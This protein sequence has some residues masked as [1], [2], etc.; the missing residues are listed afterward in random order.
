MKNIKI[1]KAL[2]LVCVIAMLCQFILVPDIMVS[3]E[4]TSLTFAD[5]GVNDSTAILGGQIWGQMSDYSDVSSLAGQSFEG[6]ITLGYTE[7][8]PY[9]AAHIFAKD[10]GGIG[11]FA[12]G[13]EL[14]GVGI[15][16]TD[17]T[18]NTTL[19]SVPMADY[20]ITLTEGVGFTEFKLSVIIDAISGRDAVLLI[21]LNDQK[22]FAGT[23]EGAASFLGP[24]AFVWGFNAPISI[25]S[26]CEVPAGVTYQ[27]VSFTDFNMADQ[28]FAAGVQKTGRPTDITTLDGVRI[29][30]KLQ[31]GYNGNDIQHSIRFGQSEATG[32]TCWNG[33]GF[34][35]QSENELVLADFVNYNDREI[36][37]VLNIADYN[38]TYTN[39]MF[40]EFDFT[41]QFCHI[42]D[43][44]HTWVDVA[45]NGIP[46]YS[47][48]IANLQDS[49]GCNIQ[50]WANGAPIRVTSLEKPVI[51]RNITFADF[52]MNDSEVS[53]DG[54]L[55]GELNTYAD[56]SSLAGLAFEGYITLGYTEAHPLTS[57]HVFGK[58]AGGIGVFA[59]GPEQL[60]IGIYNADG[61]KNTT[62]VSV[63]IAD[64][65]ISYTK[66]IGFS[67]FKL[68]VKIKA[69]SGDNVSLIIALNDQQIYANTVSG[70]A[71]LLGPKTFVWGFN[72]PIIIRSTYA[73]PEETPYNQVSFLDFGMA[74]Q[75]FAAG[76][77]KTGR[78]TDITTLDG[79]CIAGKLQMGYN[80]NDIQH[81]IRFGQSEAAGSTCWNG[82]GFYAKSENELV[83]ADFTNHNSREIIKILNI[84][85]YD[86]TYADG[87]FG[88][89]DFSIKFANIP[90]SRHMWVDVTVN[91]K[92]FYSGLLADGQDTLDCNIQLWANGATIGVKSVSP[93]PAQEVT[94][95][96]FGMEHGKVDT[97][98]QPAGELTGVDNLNNV[99]FTG[100]LT[101]TDIGGSFRIGTKHGKTA[102]GWNGIGIA[103]VSESRLELRSYSSHSS[104]IWLADVDIANCGITY[105][106]ATGF[107]QFLLRITFTYVGEQ[108]VAVKVLINGT[109]I[110]SG[111]IEN[112]Q[113]SLDKGIRFDG[114]SPIYYNSVSD[115]YTEVTFSDF[116]VSDITLD[117]T[118]NNQAR[119]VLPG[120]FTSMDGVAFFGKVQ[121][122]CADEE[123]WQHGLYVGTNEN[124]DTGIV[125]Y[126]VN[127]STLGIWKKTGSGFWDGGRLANININ[128]C[129]V[130][131]DAQT[132]FSEFDLQMYFQF[133]GDAD[134]QMKVVINGYT[135]YEDIVT[136]MQS[137]MGTRMFIYAT[138][139]PIAVKSVS[140]GEYFSREDSVQN[141]FASFCGAEAVSFAKHWTFE[142][143]T[144]SR[145][146]G[147][148]NM[149][150]LALK[151]RIYKNFELSVQYYQSANTNDA[152][153]VGMGAS[154]A[155]KFFTDESGNYGFAISSG[156]SLGNRLFTLDADSYLKEGWHTI[157]FVVSGKL[158]KAY[159]DN[160][161]KFIA[162]ALPV[163]YSGGYV[164]LASGSSTSQLRNFAITPLSDD[165][166]CI[167]DAN[168]NTSV[169]LADL[170]RLKKHIQGISG[171]DVS[172]ASVDFNND[173]VATSNDLAMLRRYLLDGSVKLTVSN[174]IH[175]ED[176]VMPIGGYFGPHDEYVTDAFYR[177]V[178]E[179]GINTIVRTDNNYIT[180]PDTVFRSLELADQYHVYTFVHDSSIAGTATAVQRRELLQRYMQY[181]YFAGLFIADEPGTNYYYA[182]GGLEDA[183]NRPV[184]A[185]DYAKEI[186]DISGLSGYV[187]LLP[188]YAE[189]ECG[190][191]N[192]K[193][194]VQEYCTTVP[195]AK[196]LSF[197][198]YPFDISTG[199]IFKQYDLKTYFDNMTVIRDAA[200]NMGIPFWGFIRNQS[201]GQNLTE[202]MYQ[203]NVNTN[204]AMGAKGIEYYTLFQKNASDT[205]DCLI[206][207]DGTTTQAYAYA[208]KINAQIANMDEILMQ[209]EHKGIIA[210]GSKAQQHTADVNCRLEAFKE[211]TSVTASN[212]ALVGCFEYNDKTVLCVVNYDMSYAQ[213]ITLQF[214]GAKSLTM[215]T[216]STQ[217]LEAAQ[218]HTIRLGAGSAA[219]LVVE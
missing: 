61:S 199:I 5:F 66:D 130:T 99:A 110:Y 47:G 108:N 12:N 93:A 85:D 23:A 140:V 54:Q 168:E 116:G 50:L 79:V 43:T 81:S 88:E 14:L 218:S 10:A 191:E 3:A 105:Q 214:S 60:G 104:Y 4:E 41:I 63:P 9:T 196:Y 89:F 162:V 127:T 151:D 36:I 16:N 71:S 22:I 28:T 206:K 34:Y 123:D 205:T 186:N 111:I 128:D 187:N 76:V 29:A 169:N 77:Q 70:I 201:K 167:G 62:L 131:Y 74:D 183:L 143:G 119:G 21:K 210:V 148:E 37:N 192:Y 101:F 46:F 87:M 118:G 38:I 171:A 114:T 117:H 207:R 2:A 145:K 204:L 102:Y 31:M 8:H 125:V 42:A 160:A 7:A 65:G 170:V 163:A 24:K 179:S 80:G 216:S 30:G 146:A 173:N 25:R 72:A 193:R 51:Y 11:V 165:S 91:E 17:G 178:A 158:V 135:V 211:L 164:Y 219:L 215:Y 157:R 153:I 177:L 115:R 106:H 132:G 159:V 94:F 90:E 137:L 133:V 209:S 95:A 136:Q 120:Q 122:N 189:I 82:I 203:W 15:Y 103:P 19:V 73:A 195:N 172:I 166:A 161:D 126:P 147:A 185:Y 190:F 68:G 69:V 112:L 48:L 197:D 52:G 174:G 92:A 78:P 45:I 134:V 39:G 35:A 53:R 155:G 64:Y 141:H 40:S 121:F 27:Q 1:K 20:G 59:N 212:G 181:E 55:W 96:D 86:I 152:L 58:D 84:A 182:N 142:N 32:S 75:T 113:S 100:R 198:H 67:E 175:T 150:M 107:S 213:N 49:L 33:I 97:G 124:G 200:Y 184:S 6:Y 18:K 129:G 154:E 188:Y 13:P 202:G 44:R 139:S 56:V 144:V 26:A 194:Y 176:N 180:S 149:V 156:N 138:R 83:L 98:R 57:A 217:L 109:Q 208:Q